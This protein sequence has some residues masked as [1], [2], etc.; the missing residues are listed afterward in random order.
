MNLKE[1]VAS[2]YEA[3]GHQVEASYK[4]FPQLVVASSPGLGGTEYRNVW[5]QE[6]TPERVDKNWEKSVLNTLKELLQTRRNGTNIFLVYNREGLSK[7][8]AGEIRALGFTMVAEAD[9][10]DATFRSELSLDKGITDSKKEIVD[11]TKKLENLLIPQPYRKVHADSQNEGTKE[12]LVKDLTNLFSKTTKD[13]KVV[14]LVGPAGAGKS[15]AFNLIYAKTYDHFIERKKKREAACRPIPLTPKHI[16]RN[17]GAELDDV[18]DSFI[19]EEV[20]KSLKKEAFNWLVDAGYSS[21]FIDGLDEIL[22]SDTKVFDEYFLDR[23]TAAGSRAKVLLC[24]RDSLLQS[25]TE[26]KN[27]IEYGGDGLVEILELQPWGK[28]QHREFSKKVHKKENQEKFNSLVSQEAIKPI[29]QNAFCC[30]QIAELLESNIQ[31]IPRNTFDLYDTLLK[32]FLEREKSKGLFNRISIKSEDIREYLESIGEEYCSKQ[33]DKLHL[34]ELKETARIFSA[35]DEEDETIKVLIKLPLIR[36]SLDG[37]GITFVHESWGSFLLAS[38]LLKSF[39]NQSNINQQLLLDL[40]KK[41]DLTKVPDVIKLISDK[42]EPSESCEFLIRL[43]AGLE[44]DDDN[45]YRNILSIILCTNF[46]NTAEYDLIPFERRNLGGI[47]FDGCDL[48]GVSFDGC[49]LRGAIFKN[50][51]LS[52]TS[53]KGVIFEDTLVDSCNL[54]ESKAGNLEFFSSLVLEGKK[55]FSPK[56]AVHLWAN[57]Y[58]GSLETAV[59]STKISPN[60]KAI[61]I[62]FMKFFKSAGQLGRHDFSYDGFTHIRLTPGAAPIRELID[63][64]VKTG[65]FRMRERPRRKILRPDGAKLDEMVQFVKNDKISPD[66]KAVINE[67][68][69]DS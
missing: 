38:R 6:S 33:E 34:D 23:L 14:I 19:Q 1:K 55:I 65:F 54:D 9:F 48:S 52:R 17:R 11:E 56:D 13:P 59:E 41:V 20:S 7:D 63:V 18:I 57:S 61:R 5:V 12:D 47:R 32:N 27:F 60:E 15:A 30:K 51:N 31:A 45:S 69:R 64:L 49:N 39:D 29:A 67:L 62:L 58:S 46:K 42:I 10:F 3:I 50:C 22:A 25:C 21:L 35:E 53:F 4:N 2:F 24:V 28:E 40:I 43:F 26:L 37:Q 66:L 8:F 36:K 68:D 44:E 16:K